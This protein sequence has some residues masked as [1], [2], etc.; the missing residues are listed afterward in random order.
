MRQRV[1][2][3]VVL[4]SVLF[5]VPLLAASSPAISGAVSGIEL[6]PQFICGEAVFAGAFTGTI[7]QK[8]TAGA[9]WTGI[10]HDDLPTITGESSAITGG[11]WI[12]SARRKIYA[13]F[14]A[15]G[16]TLTYNGDNTYTVSLTMVLTSGGTGTMN[17]VGLLDHNEFPP[18]ITG[19]ITQ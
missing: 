12:I 4:V 7:G 6:C 19:T 11:S 18:T 13:G 9:F 2:A 17:F 8:A 16:G 1:S 14:V 3:G 10:T 15:P 5:A